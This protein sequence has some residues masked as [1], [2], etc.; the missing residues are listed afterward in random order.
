MAGRSSIE[1]TE[2]TWNPVTGCDKVSPGCDNCLDP[3][4]PVLMADLSERPIGELQVG[5]KVVGFTEDLKAGKTRYYEAATV[6]AVWETTQEAYELDLGDRR[7]VASGDHRFL[8]QPGHGWTQ[9]RK[10]NEASWMVEVDPAELAGGYE[11]TA[12]H[13]EH[14]IPLHNIRPVGGR[15]LID[16]TTSSRTFVAAGLATHNCYALAFA[17]RLNAA[18][19]ARYQNDG[20]PRTSG[21]GFGLTCHDDLVDL[22]LR[23]RKPRIV[24]VNSMSD[25]FHPKVPLEFIQRLFATME[26]CPQHTFQILT[27]RSQRML[28]LAEKLPWPENVWMGVSVENAAYT[29]RIEHLRQVPAAVRFLSLEPLLDDPGTLGLE[30]I[31]W[32]V[33]GGESGP[34]ARPMEADWARSVRDQCLKQGV[35]F[36]FKQWGGRTS[37]AGGRLLDGKLW[38]QRPS[39]TGGSNTQLALA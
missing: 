21:P 15:R 14:G 18:G 24:F 36:Y 22:P 39:S 6:E 7:I 8:T 11:G 26:A 33:V 5:D 12:F 10:L 37:K 25:I 32:V 16:I 38:S 34:K 29:F 19:N 20:D 30:G 23:W 17:K 2:V 9:T 1:W 27:K 35:A 13:G 31:H 28:K 3:A 4:T